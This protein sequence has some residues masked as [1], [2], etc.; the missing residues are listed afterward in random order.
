MPGKNRLS[1][2]IESDN[3]RMAYGRYA[4]QKI[5]VNGYSILK[6]PEGAAENGNLL[7]TEEL[8]KIIFEEIK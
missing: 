8:Y 2:E 5:A 1:I 4:G 3:I 7:L 6:T